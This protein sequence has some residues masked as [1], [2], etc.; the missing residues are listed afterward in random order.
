MAS[1]RL[2]FACLSCVAWL[3]ACGGEPGADPDAGVDAGPPAGWTC[4]PRG[5]GDG[6]VCHCECGTPDPDCASGELIVSGCV[7]DQVCTPSGTCSDCGNGEVDSGEAC[8]VALDAK[9]ECG[10]LGYEPG[11]VPCN[12]SCEWAYDQCVPLATCGNGMLDAAELCDDTAIAPGLDCTDYGKTSGTLA[13]GSSCQIDASG[14]YTCGD[15]MVD[16]PE[17]CDD[18][19][20]GS[21]DGCSST[22]APETGWRCVGEPSFCAPICGDGLLVGGEACDDGNANSNDGCSAACK[23]EQDCTCSGTPSVCSCAVVQL[24]TTTTQGIETGSLALDAA[25]QP[26]VAYYYSVDF[27]DPVTGYAREHSHVVYA[28]RS[29]STWTTSEIQTWD[30]TQSLM[31][32]E[33]LI[34]AHD[35]GTLRA[36]FHRLYHPDGTFAVATRSGSSWQLAYDD[37]YYVYDTVRAGGNWHALVAGANIVDF[38]YYM[39]APGAWTLDEP[40]TGVSSSSPARLGVASNGDVY[41]AT[42][43]RGPSSTSYNLKLSKRTGAS[44]WSTVYDVATTGTCVY[45]ID[46]IPLALANGGIM[47]FEQGFNEAKQRWLRAHR[48]TGTSWVVEDVADMSWLDS[49]C[50]SSSWSYSLV[51]LVSAVDHLG[52]PHILYPS[53]PLSS[54]QTLEDHYRDATGWKVRK[55]PLT[56]GRALDMVIDASGTTHILAIAP[57][58]TPGTHRILYIRVS[59][60]A[61]Q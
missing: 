42:I 46:H 30:Q 28:R 5:F 54:S 49:S 31:G 38:R 53:P 1:V 12:A 59:E 39:G 11:Q 35:S 50:K 19:D 17:A 18:G 15:G 13:C 14:C 9:A 58:T 22:C 4:D 26:H 3:V 23:V 8:D 52:Q 41:L 60:N 33:D 43:S 51:R 36:Y 24:I 47:A 29:G 21:G 61:W 10:P 44:T 40:L 32:P 55:F 27:T 16:G 34:L 6:V 25:G 57:S 20:T 48:F 37:P 7:N 45:A 2:W 56:H